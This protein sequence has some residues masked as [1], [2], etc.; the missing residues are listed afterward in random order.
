MAA[1]GL[2]TG[3]VTLSGGSASAD[4]VKLT[5][6]YTCKFPIINNDPIEVEI[7]ADMPATMKVGETVPE[8]DIKA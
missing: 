2:V 5:Q 6:K 1:A 4:P 3:L 8:Y 7:T